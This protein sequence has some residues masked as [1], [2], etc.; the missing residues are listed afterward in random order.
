MVELWDSR[1]GIR[2]VDHCS[3]AFYIFVYRDHLAPS[4]P[5]LALIAGRSK[6]RQRCILSKSFSA[7]PLFANCRFPKSAPT[8][9]FQ[10][11]MNGKKRITRNGHENT[12]CQAKTLSKTSISLVSSAKEAKKAVE[13]CGVC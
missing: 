9:G 4:T 13:R 6:Q 2:A 3:T 7:Y 11:A 5:Y 8:I 1:D 10:I 12:N